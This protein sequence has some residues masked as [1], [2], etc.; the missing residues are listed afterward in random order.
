[1]QT[2]TFKEFFEMEDN[3]KHKNNNIYVLERFTITTVTLF[4]I[5]KPVLAKN[6]GESI[7]VP[8]AGLAKLFILIAIVVWFRIGMHVQDELDKAKYYN[9]FIE[10]VENGKVIELIKSM[11]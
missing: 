3:N 11:E 1:M 2:M 8:H 9:K 5:S 10:A 7:I 6:I 4:N